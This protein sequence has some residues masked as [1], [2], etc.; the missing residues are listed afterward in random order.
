MAAISILNNKLD[1]SRTFIS[2]VPV[3]YSGSTI[4]TCGITVPVTNFSDITVTSLALTGMRELNQ[5]E[6][7]GKIKLS[8]YTNAFV[9][10]SEDA[11]MV[12]LVGN[13]WLDVYYT[14]S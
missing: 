7:T 9:I 8:K 4:S 5:N 10:Y 1:T 11:A 14:V 13:N 6:W 2:V 12:S 3:R